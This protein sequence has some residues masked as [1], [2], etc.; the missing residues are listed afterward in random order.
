MHNVN[1][2]SKIVAIDFEYLFL[3]ENMGYGPIFGFVI[4]KDNKSGD[5]TL[6]FNIS[7]FPDEKSMIQG[8]FRKL[9]SI[10][11]DYVLVSFLDTFLSLISHRAEALGV[12]L[13][14]LVDPD[15]KYPDKNINIVVGRTYELSGLILPLGAWNYTYTV[16][17]PTNFKFLDLITYYNNNKQVPSAKRHR[18]AP[19]KLND[20]A[21]E[22]LGKG[23][24]YVGKSEDYFNLSSSELMKYCVDDTELLHEVMTKLVGEKK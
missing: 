5:N 20:I 4:V 2:H 15:N 18:N 13:R 21:K 16:E 19:Y 1:K 9:D 14:E 10:N 6:T 17:L 7:D 3:R 8:F 11:Y 12:P 22:V 24:K 23:I